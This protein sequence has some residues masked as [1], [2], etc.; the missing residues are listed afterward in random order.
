[1]EGCIVLLCCVVTVRG[2]DFLRLQS[3]FVQGVHR[4]LKVMWKESLNGE[5]GTV[6]VP[7]RMSRVVLGCFWNF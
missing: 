7:L 2:D 1:M 6:D 3:N 5:L 4:N